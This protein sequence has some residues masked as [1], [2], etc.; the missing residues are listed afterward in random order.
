MIVAVKEFFILIIQ[1]G[2][3][4]ILAVSSDGD[5]SRPI[6]KDKRLISNETTSL[7]MTNSWDEIRVVLRVFNKPE[8][9]PSLFLVSTDGYYNSFYGKDGDENEF[10]AMACGYLKMINEDGGYQKVKNN[11]KDILSQ[12]SKQGS[13]DDITLGII[14][15]KDS[16]HDN[17]RDWY[18]KGTSLYD[19]KKYSEAIQAFNEALK[20]DTENSKAWYKKGRALSRLKKYNEAIKC[21]DE[22]I[23]IN[24]EDSDAWYNKGCCLDRNHE[25]AIQCYD[26]VIRINPEDSDAWYNKGVALRQ[27]KKMEEAAK[28][29][30][31]SK[32]FESTNG[33]KVR[34]R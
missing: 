31:K 30:E 11:L 24:P 34:N 15:N 5:V 26:E 17:F 4:D 18:D 6:E 19:E 7:C 8:S 13:G 25:M 33:I 29:F 23:R 10:R 32:S 27:L 2:D 12:T 9:I 21:Y 1:I 16:I 28:C 22:A 20:V 3:G 14:L